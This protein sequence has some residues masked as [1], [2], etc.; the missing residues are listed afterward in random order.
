[1]TSHTSYT[2]DGILRTPPPS[3][4]ALAAEF[5]GYSFDT[6]GWG[7]DPDILVTSLPP[8]MEAGLPAHSSTPSH[9]SLDLT[10]LDTPRRGPLPALDISQRTP[11]TPR[12]NIRDLNSFPAY[13]PIDA[14]EQNAHLP[15]VPAILRANHIAATSLRYNADVGASP[16][17]GLSGA[18]GPEGKEGKKGA[19]AKKEKEN[20]GGQGDASTSKRMTGEDLIKVVRA[21]IDVNP[22]LAPHGQKGGA[23]ER[24]AIKL[25][26]EGFRHTSISAASV[27]HKAEAL[28]SY[29]KNPNGKHKNLANVI[30]EGTSSSITIGALLERLET[31]HDTAKGKSDEAK[32]KLKK[33]AET[34]RGSGG[35]R[36]HPSGVDDD[37]TDQE[38]DSPSSS[39]RP[40]TAADSSLETLD[41][42]DD[43]TTNGKKAS[44]KPASKRRRGM[45]RSASSE[46]DG[47]LGLMKA[48]NE[49]RAAH[50]ARVA[51]S[52]DTFVSDLRVQK[53]EFTSLLKE[54]VA[55]DRKADSV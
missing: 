25:A 18:K 35:R 44:K 36:G 40:A 45:R 11:F 19:G 10:T 12:M 48:E 5:P 42:D 46:A 51:Q 38:T 28:I 20:T 21:A 17:I 7:E 30:G 47:L 32:A 15:H 53:Q 52:L 41:S 24:V 26:E 13:P 54:L 23:W 8:H 2:W 27:Q 6:T 31:A 34:R 4:N 43:D 9:P 29:K 39:A 1:M 50:D 14:D 37:N 55:N 3:L 16:A 49:R 22:F 33:P